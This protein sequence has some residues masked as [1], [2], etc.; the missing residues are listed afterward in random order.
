MASIVRLK[1]KI[2]SLGASF[3]VDEA[4]YRASAPSGFC[5]EHGLHE[6][7]ANHG[8]MDMTKPEAREELFQRVEVYGQ[9]EKCTAPN[10]EWCK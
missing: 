10:C 7:V 8:R 5:W 2:E 6:L 9:I 3:V 4:C 1:E